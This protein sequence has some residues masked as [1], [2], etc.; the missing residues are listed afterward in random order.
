MVTDGSCFHTDSK[1]KENNWLELTNC[2]NY[3][4]VSVCFVFWCT[5]SWLFTQYSDIL[6]KSS[7]RKLVLDKS[8]D[9][10]ELVQ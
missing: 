5:Y 9:E 3:A 6:R 2:V 4:Y 10:Q 7:G 1:L 8:T